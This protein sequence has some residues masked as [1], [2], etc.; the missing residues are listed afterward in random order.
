MDKFNRYLSSNASFLSKNKALDEINEVFKQM[1]IAHPGSF[2]RFEHS[3][4]SAHQGIC[5]LSWT[6]FL[7][8]THPPFT[9]TGYQIL[10]HSSHTTGGLGHGH[11]PS[12][13]GERFISGQ[14][15]MICWD[16]LS[17]L[18]GSLLLTL[19]STREMGPL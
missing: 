2:P 14:C 4:F 18:L 7:P 12:T 10:T 16:S 8:T 5:V 19:A 6:L 9:P 15:P 1:N 11:G 3:L 13:R 17:Y